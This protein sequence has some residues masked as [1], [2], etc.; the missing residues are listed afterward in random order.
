M[1]DERTQFLGDLDAGGRR[2]FRAE[3][4]QCVQVV[5]LDRVELQGASQ[6]LEDVGGHG[7]GAAL[8][9]LRKPGNGDPS[10]RRELLT[11]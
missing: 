8:F 2:A 10:E 5:T 11:P 4:G 1:V 6:R 9:E 7:L 3:P